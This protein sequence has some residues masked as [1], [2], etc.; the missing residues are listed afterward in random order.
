M[1]DARRRGTASPVYLWAPRRSIRRPL[2][3][4]ARSDRTR[5]CA[6]TCVRACDAARARFAV[7]RRRRDT[8]RARAG[9][10]LATQI[11]RARPSGRTGI[12]A[13]PPCR[14][15]R[16]RR[17]RSRR[18][19][20]ASRSSSLVST[21]A[22]GQRAAARVLGAFLRVCV[23]A[24]PPCT[25]LA[26]MTAVAGGDE[27]ARA[28]CCRLAELATVCI[29]GR[30]GSAEGAWC[31][32]P[33][34]SARLGPAG[35]CVPISFCLALGAAFSWLAVAP[36]GKWWWW[37]WW[38]APSATVDADPSP[39]RHRRQKKKE[40]DAE[41]SSFQVQVQASPF[42]DPR[43]RLRLK[44]RTRGGVRRFCIVPSFA[45]PR[46]RRSP[47]PAGT[48]G[49]AP[50]SEPRAPPPSRMRWRFSKTTRMSDEG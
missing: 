13:R 15:L 8:A 24:H 14:R 39:R 48:G 2:I 28:A 11:F 40:R 36:R 46:T 38:C 6:C 29:R 4:P 10:S 20:A 3:R 27:R 37:W 50:F 35:P 1:P 34:T 17:S 26:P 7:R 19:P 9:S 49:S 44:S 25:R 21:S 41:L 33:V 12:L 45:P 16:R 5:A 31:S 32:V 18:S 30:G 42:R 43:P 22:R 47:H 23:P